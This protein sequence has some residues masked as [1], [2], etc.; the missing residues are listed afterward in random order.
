[1]FSTSV[2]LVLLAKPLGPFEITVGRL[3]SAAAMVWILARLNRQPLF[4]RRTD[5]PRFVLFG[6]ITALHFLSYIASLSFTTIA[7]SLAI[8]YTAPIFVAPFLGDNAARAD[9]VAEMVGRGGDCVGI[10]ILVGFQPQ[11]DARMAF[12]DLLC[13]GIGDHLRPLFGGG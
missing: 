8:V 2:V 10:A 12:G 5:W 13:P 3:S 7:Q 4:P 1:M 11:M 6:L 9:L